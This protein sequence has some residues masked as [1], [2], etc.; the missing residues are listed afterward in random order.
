M[1]QQLLTTN[2][3]FQAQANQAA[4][5]SHQ[6]L[7]L[8]EE[9]RYKE[10]IELYDWSIQLQPDNDRAWYGRGDALA[11]LGRYEEALSSFNQAVKLNSEHAEAWTFRGVVLIHLKR[12]R[13]AL[14]SCDRA[15][16]I[17]PQD[18][19]AWTFRGVA[20][21][22]LGR[23]KDAYSSYDRATNM[24]RNSIGQQF[25][26]L[27]SRLFNPSLAKQNQPCSEPD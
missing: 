11:N 14:E 21:Q 9:K 22:R 18:Q 1:E 8:L 3:S 17:H 27:F 5:Q 26:Q 16:A 4:P 10:A 24:Q 19:E 15:L 20:L 25:T 12:Y 2:Q 13:E 23:Y 7:L 6:G